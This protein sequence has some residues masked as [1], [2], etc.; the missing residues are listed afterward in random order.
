MKMRAR[1]ALISTFLETAINPRFIRNHYHNQLYRCRILSERAPA[2]KA[3][4]YFDEEFFQT[5]RKLK[6]SVSN[7]EDISIKQVYDFLMSSVLNKEID[8]PAG[9]TALPFS[10][11]PLKPLNC[12]SECPD[13]DWK[14]SWRLARQRGIGPDLSSFILKL[15]W[16]LI[17]TRDTLHRFFPRQYASAVCQLCPQGL[18]AEV[19]T[20][21]HALGDCPANQGLLERLLT[22]IR[23][24]QPGACT[25]SV[26]TLDLE[27]DHSLELPIT[28]AIGSLLFSIFNQRE[29]GRVT[30]LRT[31]A[32][33]ESGCR[34]LGECRIE[35]LENFPTLCRLLVNDIFQ[36]I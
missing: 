36:G 33:P 12:E 10:E 4:P 8:P 9:E 29:M 23:T 24:H 6:K 35:G 11:W 26:F 19:E 27:L 22:V 5:I 31:K 15:L 28:W 20:L 21:H 2:L 14:R 3:L 13:T 25:R 7:I 18:P 1:A 17:P 30:I 32:D 16:K 34:M